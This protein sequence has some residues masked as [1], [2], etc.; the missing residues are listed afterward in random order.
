LKSTK[1]DIYVYEY[2]NKMAD[3]DVRGC[4]DTHLY[5]YGLMCARCSTVTAA[6]V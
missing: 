2:R 3:V 4:V 1:I 5:T 6:P